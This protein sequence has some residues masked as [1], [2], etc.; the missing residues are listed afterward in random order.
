MKQLLDYLQEIFDDDAVWV[1]IVDANWFAD[2]LTLT[3]SLRF[4]NREP[5]LW[6]VACEG[7]VEE[8]L[9]SKGAS[10]LRVST[11]SLL[12]KPFTEPDVAVMFSEN[13][14]APDLLL[15]I[16]CGC[17][18][19]VSGTMANV[20]QCMNGA[21]GIGELTRSK[22][23]LLGRFPES[24]ATRIL[25]A[26]KDKP[27]LVNALPGRR[28][29]RWNGSEHV[30]YQDLQVLEIGASYVIAQQFNASRA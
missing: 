14:M 26:L 1:R 11:D 21:L 2:D 16:V 10:G 13:E 6:E 5:E 27:I 12:L 30:H 28:P 7:V 9:C 3:L 24:L 15:G 19:E 25:D 23:G 4:D 18:L 20:P 8:S 22:F 29:T 17:F